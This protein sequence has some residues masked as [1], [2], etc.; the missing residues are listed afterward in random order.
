MRCIHEAALHKQNSFVTLTYDDD[1]L[2]KDKGLDKSHLQ[3][4]FKRL[5]KA[6]P[7]KPI[8]YYAC[9]EYGDNTK[10]PHYHACVFGLDFD[11]KIHFRTLGQNALYLSEKLTN[12][13][14]HGNTS[15]GE[16]T[17]ETA[18]YTARYVMKKS[19]GGSTGR[20]VRLDEATGELLELTQ[21]FAAMSLRPAIALNWV[22]RYY[23]DI[24]VPGKDF[25]TVR[26]RKMKPAKY[27]DKIF[28]SINSPGMAAIKEDRKTNS[29]QLSSQQLRARESNVRARL[30]TRTQL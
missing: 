17:Y 10:R 2:P 1:H 18:A 4:F 9:G 26:G 6:F 20:Y 11:D 23:S 13:W 24:Y 21:P 8:R 19:L 15:V 25:I 27:Y 3:R 12:I 5:R 28:D 30:T 14:G 22:H 16:L 29:E 7:T